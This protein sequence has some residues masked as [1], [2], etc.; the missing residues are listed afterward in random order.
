M[1]GLNP[2]QAQ[3][4]EE[5]GPGYYVPNVFIQYWNMR[6]MGYLAVLV[7]LISV[8]ALAHTSQETRDVPGVPVGG[9]M[10]WTGFLH[11]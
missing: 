11:P 1:V 4:I 10:G 2:L 9:G 7:F 5:Y 6:V 3:Y 8:G